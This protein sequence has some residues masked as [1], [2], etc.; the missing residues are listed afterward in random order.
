MTTYFT[1]LDLQ[2]SDKI[3]LNKILEIYYMYIYPKL[4][5]HNASF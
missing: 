4:I 5:F 1:F 3:A 2:I